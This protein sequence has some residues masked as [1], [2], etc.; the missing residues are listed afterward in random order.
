MRFS[1]SICSLRYLRQYDGVGWVGATI[2]TGTKPLN[3]IWAAR[4]GEVFAVGDN[5][6][7][8]VGK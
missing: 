1:A 2:P 5:G 6:T 8:V 3:A 7:I 4:T